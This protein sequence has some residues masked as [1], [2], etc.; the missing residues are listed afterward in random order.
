VF[1]D[2]DEF[3]SEFEGYLLNTYSKRTVKATILY[4]KKYY[5]IITGANAQELLKLSDQKRMHVM[6]ALASFSKYIGCYDKWQDIRNKYQLRWAS[7]NGLEIFNDIITDS[8]GN[9]ASMVAW[10][11]DVCSKLPTSYGNI[12]LY[13]TLTGLRPDEACK[14][15]SLIHKEEHNYLKKDIMALEHFKYP[16]FFIRRTKKAYISIV[17]VPILE[18][19]RQSSVCGYN[20]LRLALKRRSLNMNMAYCRK[21]YATNLR[22]NGIEQEIIDLLQGRTPKS[23]FVRNYFRPDYQYDRIRESINSLYRSLIVSCDWV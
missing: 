18:L 23:V 3:W 7:P 2:N 21:I 12:L 16:E 20:A 9:Y 19:A 6:K 5:N 1:P 10:L 14:S 11:E 17:T 13:N 22:M 15:I 4:S 8:K